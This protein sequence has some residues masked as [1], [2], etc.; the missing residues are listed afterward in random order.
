MDVAD[1]V[2]FDGLRAAFPGDAC[3]GDT[4]MPAFMDGLKVVFAREVNR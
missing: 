3:E 1:G 2:R 4:V